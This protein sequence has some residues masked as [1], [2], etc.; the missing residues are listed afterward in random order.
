VDGN[1]GMA[2]PVVRELA[3]RL[4]RAPL[5][6]V[7]DLSRPVVDE[8]PA[9]PVTRLLTARRLQLRTLV[10][11]LERAAADERVSGLVA[12]VERPADSWAH[13]EELRAAVQAVAAAGKRTVAHAQTFGEVGDGTLAYYT[14]VAFDEIH[15]QPS[16]EVGLT[17]LAAEVPFVAD[18]LDKL[19][20]AAE[21]DHRHEYKAAKNLLTER[22]F[23]AP[24]RE[25]V[26]RIVASH[27]EQ[28]VAA[29]ATGRGIDPAHAG[30]LV[31]RGPQPGGEALDAGLVDRLA[32][33]DETLAEVQSGAGPQ[34]RLVTLQR[35]GGGRRRLRR[36]RAGVALIHGSGSIAVGRSRRSPFGSVLGADT[37]VAAFQQ[38]IRHRR[39]RAI[40]FRVDSPGGS[41]VASDAI[42]RAVV[43]AREAG[44]PVVV[45]MGAVA[46]SGGYWVA[47]AADRIV[48]SPG[49]LTGSIGVVLG[50][51][52]TAGLQE[53]A[54]ITTDEAHRGEAAL[55]YSRN[56]R[57]TP[58]QW[59]RVGATLDRI[60]DQFVA[61]VAAGRGLAR[62]EVHDLA[63][64]RVWTGADAAAR[65]LVDELGGYRVAEEAVR[66]LLDLPA[67]AALRLRSFPRRPLLERLG[68]RRAAPED[69]RALAAALGD[70]L[71]AAG[72]TGSGA[73]RMPGWTASL[74]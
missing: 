15:L 70:G 5:V 58:E 26:E 49:T 71:R 65:G 59:D 12:R 34:A 30:A 20:V 62:E 69:A 18:L 31:D 29:I 48:A 39:V 7:V 25:A 17:G 4:G 57:F 60:Y 51:L 66:R 8:P 50:K 46:G 13:A 54:G 64:G 52:V 53:R 19:G 21:L 2:R 22:G 3:G 40:L 43:R 74:R 9:S 36:P 63:R 27:H 35:Y 33:R 38:A 42:W 23:T 10:E 67:G 6:L 45:S 72:M 73:A 24:H 16:G 28:L 14:A 56:Q 55:L 61:K 11:A 32:Y 37:V 44:K 68:L 41:A 1:G 47:M